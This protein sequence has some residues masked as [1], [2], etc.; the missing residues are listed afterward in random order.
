MSHIKE[1]KE[2]DNFPPNFHHLDVF[3]LYNLRVPW[4][5]ITSEASINIVHFDDDR[6]FFL[7]FKSLLQFSSFSL[8]PFPFAHQCSFFGTSGH[9]AL[10]VPMDSFCLRTGPTTDFIIWGNQ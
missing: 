5:V 3:P 1:P 2:E 9:K 6:F 8:T 7:N 4:I 10:L